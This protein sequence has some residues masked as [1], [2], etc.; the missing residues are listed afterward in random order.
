MVANVLKLYQNSV[1]EFNKKNKYCTNVD[2]M[3]FEL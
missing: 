1:Y 3:S 2:S